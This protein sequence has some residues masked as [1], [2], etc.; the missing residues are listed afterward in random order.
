M[1]WLVL[2]SL[3]QVVAAGSSAEAQPRAEAKIACQQKGPDWRR[4]PMRPADYLAAYPADA[5]RGGVSGSAVLDCVVSSADQPAQCS[6]VKESPDG[7]GFGAAAVKLSRFYRFRP[8]C[9]ADVG[10]VSLPM[11]FRAPN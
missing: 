8:P 7:A 3:L 1:S 9:G 4:L 5:L 10:H 2:A 6:V 11:G